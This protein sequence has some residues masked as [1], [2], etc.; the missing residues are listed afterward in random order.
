LPSSR[1]ARDHLNRGARLYNNRSFEAAIVEFKDGALLE[2]VPAF[3]YN[4]GQAYRQLGKYQEALWHY[5]RFLTYGKPTGDVLKAVQ[6]WMAEMRAHLAN[7][8]LTMP[9]IEA[10]SEANQPRAHA[11]PP[12]ATEP[13]R[14]VGL[15]D[16]PAPGDRGDSIP[17]VGWT[18]TSAGVAAMGGAAFLFLRASSLTDQANTDPDTRTRTDLRDRAAT[19]NLA[20]AVVG[21]GGLALTATGLYMLVTH[22]SHHDRAGTASLDLGIT[23][24]SVVVFGRF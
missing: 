8:A 20:G 2:P 7:R 13:T 24:H 3:D 10:A 4:L 18:V 19:R 17:W 11:G 6:D 15:H 14:A 5:D 21:V 1:E 23:G 22:S 16:A 9:P 12:A